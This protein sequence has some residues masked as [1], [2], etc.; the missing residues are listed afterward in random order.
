MKP[1]TSDDEEQEQTAE[2]PGESDEESSRSRVVVLFVVGS[3]ITWRV[4]AAFPELAYV[5]VGSLGTIGAQKVSAWR[6]AREEGKD[7]Q[8]QEEAPPDVAAALRRLVGDDKGV[9]LTVLQK[10][11]HLPDTKAVKQLL[12]AEDIPWKAGRTRAGNGPSVRREDIPPA[13][14]PVAAHGHGDGCC[15]RSDDNS[16][17]NNRAGQ[18]EGEGI[19]VEAIG[20]GG[21]RV[22]ARADLAD[23]VDRFFAEAEK[24]RANPGSGETSA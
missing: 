12:E 6:A 17:T 13:S 9:L 24:R 19:R 8:E 4:V 2:T 23:I 5:V 14:S 11:L 3:V 1:R 7:D 15:C 10:D 21:H 20:D 22:A 16:N 18:G